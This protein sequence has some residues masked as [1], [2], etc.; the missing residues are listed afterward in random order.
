MYFRPLSDL[1]PTD[2]MFALQATAI[3]SDASTT[4]L[5][6]VIMMGPPPG[7]RD[8]DQGKRPF[9]VDTALHKYSMA[10]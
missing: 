3:A 9:S 2:A 6:D 4:P 7:W 8:T 5:P 1:A 10:F